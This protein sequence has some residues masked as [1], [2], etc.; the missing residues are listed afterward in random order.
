[1]SAFLSQTLLKMKPK[2]KEH[3]IKQRLVH[4][5]VYDLKARHPGQSGDIA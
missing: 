2:T 3:K 5:S 1:M 4:L